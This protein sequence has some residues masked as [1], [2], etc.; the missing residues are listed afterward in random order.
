MLYTVKNRSVSGFLNNFKT[1]A[2]TKYYVQNKNNDDVWV[3]CNG[4]PLSIRM[5][6]G[7]YTFVMEDV[8]EKTRAEEERK[9]AIKRRS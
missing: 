8:T 5:A 1:I 7:S 3:E 9:K 4:K 2:Q 6:V